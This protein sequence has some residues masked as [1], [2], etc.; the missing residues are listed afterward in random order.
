MA[1]RGV[2]AADAC[3]QEVLEDVSQNRLRWG[4]WWHLAV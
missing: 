2:T 3:V 4:Y 1:G